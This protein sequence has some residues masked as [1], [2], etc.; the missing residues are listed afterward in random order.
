[1]YTGG[2]IM[3][4]LLPF[5]IIGFLILSGI[6]AIATPDGKSDVNYSELDT[7]LD[8]NGLLTF[9][10]DP[11]TCEIINPK[12]GY[13]HFLGIPLFPFKSTIAFKGFKLKPIQILTDDDVDDSEDL[14]VTINIQ[15]NGIMRRINYTTSTIWNEHSG[16]HEIGL[17][18]GPVIIFGYAT[19]TAIVEDS[20]GYIASDE[21]SFL[22]I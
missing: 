22:W 3:R 20:S 2:K 21:M 17:L 10:D 11:P 7:D 18:N 14:L 12:E 15:G 13:F 19:L 9:D 6:E 8:D 5:V 16:Y 4:K 1:M